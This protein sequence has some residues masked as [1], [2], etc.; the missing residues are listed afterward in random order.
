V[1]GQDDGAPPESGQVRFISV[2]D[3]VPQDGDRN[4]LGTLT[5]AHE[6]P[7]GGRR[8]HGPKRPVLLHGR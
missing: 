7:D 1:A 4:D 8:G 3:G 2:S 5:S 6:L